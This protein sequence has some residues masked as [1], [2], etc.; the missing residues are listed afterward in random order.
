MFGH[1]D[2]MKQACLLVRRKYRLQLGL[3]FVMY[4]QCFMRRQR[5]RRRCSGMLAGA[6]VSTMINCPTQHGQGKRRHEKRHEQ[7]QDAS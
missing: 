5:A 7:K 1:V 6:I 3:G 4:D 2:R